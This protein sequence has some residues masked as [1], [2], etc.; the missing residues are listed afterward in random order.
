[1]EEKDDRKEVVSVRV[2]LIAKI[3]EVAGQTGQANLPIS[4]RIESSVLK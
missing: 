2:V 3:V 4:S 1:M